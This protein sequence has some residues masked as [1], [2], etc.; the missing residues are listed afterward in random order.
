MQKNKVIL[1]VLDGWGIKKPGPGNYISLS[2]TSNFDRY[3]KNYPNSINKASGNAVGLPS[4][5]QG[6]S[7]V[8]HLHMGAGRIVWQP[9]EKINQEIKSGAF[10]KNK[11]LRKA[12]L[13]GNK[14]GAT[15][16]LMGLCSDEGVHSHINHLFEILKIAKKN[17]IRNILIHFFADGR[18]VPEKSAKKYINAIKKQNLGKIASVCG[19]FYSMDR[20]HNYERTKEAYDMLTEGHGFKAKSAEKAIEDAY[21]RG[22]QTDYYIRPT[23]IESDYSPIKSNDTVIFF[24]FRTDRPRQLVECFCNKAFKGFKR[25]KFPRVKFFTMTDIGQ[26]MKSKYF[27]K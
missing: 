17:N 6:N 23:I 9:F 27:Y 1:M 10:E 20:D 18:D 3:I 26:N 11:N 24:N 13:N 22:D 16:H 5:V 2:K 19:R 8:G 21:K 12:I 25:N 15:L 4:G 7:E 14:N